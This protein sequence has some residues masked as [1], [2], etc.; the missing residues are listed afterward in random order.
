[1]QNFEFIDSLLQ[2]TDEPLVIIDSNHIIVFMNEKGAMQ[3]QDRGGKALIGKKVFDCHNSEQSI[4]KIIEIVAVLK[5]GEDEWFEGESPTKRTFV[6][7]VKNP[8]GNFYGYYEHY[9]YLK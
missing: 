5:S 2:T 4:R 6:R 3:Y 9:D 1:M 8:Q 7:S